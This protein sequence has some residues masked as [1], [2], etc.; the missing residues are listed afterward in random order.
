MTNAKSAVKKAPAKGKRVY[1]KRSAKPSKAF[2]KKVQSIVHKDVETKQAF[3]SIAS[4]GYGGTI[5]GSAGSVTFCL[6][7]VGQGVTEAD[8]IGDQIRAQSLKVEGWLTQS[9]AATY[10]NACRVVCRVFIVQPKLY[11]DRNE[12]IANAPSWTSA[13]LKRGPNETAFTGAIQDLTAPVN[14][15]SIT[16]YYDKL[17]TLS[18]PAFFGGNPTAPYSVALD[19]AYTT[20]YFS[21][22]FNLKN[23]LLKYTSNYNGGIS[24]TNWCPVIL[25][26]YCFVNG[27][28]ATPAVSTVSMSFTSLL[29]YED[30]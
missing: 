26:G 24:P 4:T 20:K 7:N 30:A 22:T 21:K 9:L 5:D 3:T 17:Y 29:K 23:K 18:I 12:I 14:T 2:V 8:R 25:M 15:D 11:T 1:R 28:A 16:C 19:T 27:S 13:L 10:T 6:P